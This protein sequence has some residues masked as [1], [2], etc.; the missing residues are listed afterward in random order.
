MSHW[1]VEEASLGSPLVN[2]WLLARQIRLVDGSLNVQ[3]MVWCPSA[4]SQTDQDAMF[5]HI[6]V[7]CHRI[8]QQSAPSGYIVE[9]LLYLCSNHQYSTIQS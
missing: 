5:N 8:P 3:I 4:L 9:A 6:F 7:V 1:T 2:T